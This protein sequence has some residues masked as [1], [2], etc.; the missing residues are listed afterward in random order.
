MSSE[1]KVL[2]KT[3]TF[4]VGCLILVSVGVRYDDQLNALNDKYIRGKQSL[5]AAPVW[6]NA[7][8]PSSVVSYDFLQ[9]LDNESSDIDQYG[10]AKSI[11]ALTTYAASVEGG[12]EWMTNSGQ[13]FRTLGDFSAM[14]TFSVWSKLERP[15]LSKSNGGVRGAV[16]LDGGNLGIYYTQKASDGS[17]KP[18][19]VAFAIYN[20]ALNKVVDSVALGDF[21]AREHFALGGGMDFDAA[22]STVFLAVG[23]ASATDDVIA[24]GKA[25]D[26]KS[27]FGKTLKIT[28][29]KNADDIFTISEL[30]IFTQGHR[31]PQGLAIYG[32]LVFS[33]E[34]GPM[35]GDEINVLNEG[36]NF[37]W[38]KR[39][40][41][42]KYGGEDFAY[43][44]ENELFTDPIFYFTPS[45]GISD[46]SPCP[47]K[48]DAFG[49]RPCVMV[50]AM[51]DTSVRFVKIEYFN[52]EPVVRSIERVSFPG[53]VRKVVG[54]DSSIYGFLDS[55]IIHK[56][57]YERR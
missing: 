21:E 22:T 2:L 27:F 1:M 33:V 40:F 7:Y 25:Q 28:V 43:T 36:L 24:G 12:I 34:H 3:I 44:S 46:V 39:S 14:E 15:V 42:S 52:Q 55:G 17:R 4:L 10:V 31:N 16:R 20:E 18:F 13:Y 49:Y 23:S 51:R 32:G 30:S 29:D 50:A 53:R 41:G 19:S 35:G 8:L 5:D 56:V 57:T 54:A 45:I 38:N 11:G 6:L 37:G 26:S 48:F 9:F 47:V